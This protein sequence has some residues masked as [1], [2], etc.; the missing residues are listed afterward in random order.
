MSNALPGLKNSLTSSA[1]PGSETGADTLKSCEDAR[2]IP[3][4]WESSGDRSGSLHAQQT[5][6]AVV[7]GAGFSG[8]AAAARLKREGRHNFLILERADEV[9]GTWRE[10]TYPGCACDIPS[11]LYSYSFAPRSNWSRLYATQPEILEYLKECS[12][13]LGLRE[14]IRF[15]SAARSARFD[16]HRGIWVLEIEDPRDGSRKGILARMLILAL[17]PLNRPSIP[18]IPGLDGFPGPVFHSARW[19]HSVNLQGKR[20]GVIGTGA[21]AIQVV[22]GIIDQVRELHL[23]QRSAAY[24][25]PRK[26][27]PISTSKHRWFRRIPILQKLHRL[28]IYAYNELVAG[29]VIYGSRMLNRLATLVAHRHIRRAIQDPELIEKLI[30]DYE[31]GC[32][33]ILLSDDY[34]PALARD[35]AHVIASGV[36]KIEGNRVIAENGETAQVDVLV[37]CTGFRVSNMHRFMD[38]DIR[39][40]NDI[41]LKDYWE[42]HG[43]QAYLGSVISGFP[44]MIF[45][46]GPNTGLGHN[47]MVHIMESQPNY[48]SAY[49]GALEGHPGRFLNVRPGAQQRFNKEIQSR[50]KDTSWLSGGCSSWY[51]NDRGENTVLWPGSTLSFR[52]KTRTLDWKDFELLGQESEGPF[53]HASGRPGP[54]HTPAS[55]HR[56]TVGT[57]ES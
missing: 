39:G 16:S 7:V 10:N 5:L 22:P 27:R 44:N 18:E 33:R 11:N 20:V 4:E 47:S 48:L 50:M 2:S 31:I 24:V 36:E 49:M 56:D 32:K 3:P 6:D 41:S 13:R 17:G 46:L 29:N 52:R 23:F 37:L 30:P 8:M 55:G 28:R 21:S 42:R 25:I 40:L 38:M 19:D 14:H 12:T 15:N 43:M 1:A 54:G 45:Y 53:R 57:H 26:D 9:G 35:H 51:L 34:Y